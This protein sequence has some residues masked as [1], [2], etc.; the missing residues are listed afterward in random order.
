MLFDYLQ[1]QISNIRLLRDRN[2]DRSKG[3]G[4]IEF[5]DLDSLK[6]ALELNG[7]VWFLFNNGGT[8]EQ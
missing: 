2:T 1:W 6:D 3:F 8:R 5:E 4:Y 7:E